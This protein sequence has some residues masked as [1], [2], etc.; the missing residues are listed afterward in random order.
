PGYVGVGDDPREVIM[1]FAST[2]P[3]NTYSVTLVGSGATPLKDTSGNIFNSGFVAG[4]PL[5][6]DTST[7]LLV[8]FDQSLVGVAG[9]TP[10]A[11]SGTSF[12]G[13]QILSALGIGTTG[14]VKYAQANNISASAGT[15]EFWVQ[16]HWTPS[17]V[18]HPFFEVGDPTT[19]YQN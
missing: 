4:T 10:T 14:D 16:P 5:P 3:D 18:Q 6:N 2:L 1:R 13:G 17:G 12:V 19:G 7:S 15:V 8:H 11:S 9:E